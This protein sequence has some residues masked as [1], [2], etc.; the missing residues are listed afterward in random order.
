M[1]ILNTTR[2][3]KFF[4]NCQVRLI[5]SRLSV[6]L[7]NINKHM[8]YN[9]NCFYTTC[10]QECCNYYGTCPE[11]FSR[12]YYDSSYT[13]CYYYYDTYYQ[14]KQNSSGGAIA[15]YVIGGLIA[16]VLV[17]ALIIYCKRKKAGDFQNA[18]Q[19]AMGGNNP[20]QTIMIQNPSQPYGQP[21]YGQT[22]MYG[23]QPPVYGQPVYGQPP[24]YGYPQQQGPII[25]SSWNILIWSDKIL[26]EK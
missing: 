9:S 18:Q 7:I 5:N 4:Y 12:S 24:A 22:P 10:S 20:D 23:Q 25:I 14:K 6:K 26:I 8:G 16:I 2:V 15:G 21:G 13:S 3:A 19:Q 17:V 1:N 11:D